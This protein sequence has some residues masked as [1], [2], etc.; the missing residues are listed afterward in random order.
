MT[1]QSLRRRLERL[2]K[3][4]GMKDK[5]IIVIKQCL[6]DPDMYFISGKPGDL[7]PGIDAPDY[8][9]YAN[10]K[11]GD[12]RLKQDLID[13]LEKDYLVIVVSYVKDWKGDQNV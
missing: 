3:L 1:R 7:L 13:E 8:Q 2:E 10:G 5:P 6:D 11:P 4:N 9:T 12:R